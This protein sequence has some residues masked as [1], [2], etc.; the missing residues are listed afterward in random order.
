MIYEIRLTIHKQLLQAT[1]DYS[2]VH[3]A[4]CTSGFDQRF[5][6]AGQLFHTL[7]GMYR[8]WSAEA[9]IQAIKRKVE[10]ALRYIQHDISFQVIKVAEEVDV[11][12]RP[13]PYP[14]L[15]SLM[16]LYK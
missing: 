5:F 6:V 9:D 2:A 3:T 8:I 1:P 11:H 14:V 15:G 13:I 10:S 12:F 16:S 4:M 7:G